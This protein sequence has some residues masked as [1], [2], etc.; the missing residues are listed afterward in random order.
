[1]K[2]SLVTKSMHAYLDYPVAAALIAGPFVLRL[3]D[4]SP[5]ALWISVAAGVAA[6]VL[7]I[8]TNHKLGIFR[9]LPYSAH[10]KVDALVGIAFLAV[11]TLFGFHGIDA[12]FYWLNGAAVMCVVGLHKPEAGRSSVPAIA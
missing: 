8:F 5:L 11:P 12:W 10:L 2:P 7:T 9:V 6:L 3:G 1:M 4:S